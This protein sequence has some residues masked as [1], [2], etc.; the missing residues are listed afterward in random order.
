MPVNRKYVLILVYLVIG[1]LGFFAV[2]FSGNFNILPRNQ[3]AVKEFEWDNQSVRLILHF[4]SN[5]GAFT[6][7][8][9]IHVDGLLYYP[10]KTN[11]HESFSLYFPNT[12]IPFEY[13]MLND[14][15]L[16]QVYENGGLLVIPNDIVFEN[17]HNFSGTPLLTNFDTV[18]TEEGFQDGYLIIQDSVNKTNSGKIPLEKVINIEPSDVLQ[19]TRTNN[20]I[21]GLTFYMIILS[22]VTIFSNYDK[23]IK[24]K[25]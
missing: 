25:N 23:F 7:G 15:K 16:W 2:Y 11:Q 24:I 3:V 9:Q 22:L 8:K 10:T 19:N 5:D 13:N 17:Q 12:I 20:I 14:D 4:K 6:T 21:L 1:T 18:W